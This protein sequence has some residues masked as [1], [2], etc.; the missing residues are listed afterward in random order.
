MGQPFFLAT[1]TTVRATVIVSLAEDIGKALGMGLRARLP[2]REL[3]V[4]DE[5]SL[6]EGDYLDLGKPLEGGKF[7]PPIIKSLAFS[8]K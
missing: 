4:I 6:R 7:V 8:T 2:G 5:V 1:A 3:I